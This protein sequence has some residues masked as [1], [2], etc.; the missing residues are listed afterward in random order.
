[1]SRFGE[2]VKLTSPCRQKSTR[3]SR[4]SAFNVASRYAFGTV[5]KRDMGGKGSVAQRCELA[6]EMNLS[7]RQR[8]T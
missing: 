2:A 3:R 4:R 7:D 1:L 8:H 5:F 6:A